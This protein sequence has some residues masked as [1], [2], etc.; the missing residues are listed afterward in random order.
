MNFKILMIL[1]AVAVVMSG[2]GYVKGDVG[3]MGAAGQD[4]T[5]GNDGRDGAAGPKGADGT[6]I[7][8]VPL[9]PGYTTYSTT[10]VEVGECIN[11]KLYG[12]YSSNG[13]FFTELPPGE[14]TSNGIGSAC[15]LT[16]G[17]NCAV[18]PH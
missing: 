8:I 3:P 18:T 1:L 4:G 14:Y 7:S 5:P 12:V 11:G 2:C 16:V 9:C 17:A 15:N 6:V 10:F 13:G